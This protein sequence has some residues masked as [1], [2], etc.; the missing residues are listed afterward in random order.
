VLKLNGP[1][2]PTGTK[3]TMGYKAPTP[4]PQTPS[5]WSAVNGSFVA[6]N[7]GPNTC[8]IPIDSST[9]GAFTSAAGSITLTSPLGYTLNYV[10]ALH[11]AETGTI[12]VN[13]RP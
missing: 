3:V 7:L 13:P 4:P 9:F 11:P 1:A 8:S 6:T 10:C 2:P 5:P 12:T